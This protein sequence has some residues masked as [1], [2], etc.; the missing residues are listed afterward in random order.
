MKVCSACGKEKNEVEFYKKRGGRN[1]LCAEC[2][3]CFRKK[4]SDYYAI[5]KQQAIESN[6][7]HG[8]CIHCGKPILNRGSKYCSPQCFREVTKAKTR[9]CPIC[10]NIF[11]VDHGYRKYCSQFCFG[12][13][14]LVYPKYDFIYNGSL[15]ISKDFGK[16]KSGIYKITN[17]VNG[18]CYIGQSYN[19]K[20]RIQQHRMSAANGKIR[21][22]YSAIRKYGIG[23][24]NFEIIKTVPPNTPLD[25]MDAL[26]QKYIREHQSNNPHYGY[27]ATSGGRKVLANVTQ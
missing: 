21:A 1:G 26:E 22:I 20:A 12:R 10:G 15:S 13:A 16:N 18:K 25:D 5:K 27:N 2:K 11:V 9:E 3:E 7:G 23:N 24:F 8:I 14:K 4:R 6:D 17:L 19:I